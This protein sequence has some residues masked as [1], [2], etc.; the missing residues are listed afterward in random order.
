MNFDERAIANDAITDFEHTTPKTISRTIDTQHLRNTLRKRPAKFWQ[1]YL[2]IAS[3]ASPWHSEGLV[4]VASEAPDPIVDPIAAVAVL[5]SAGTDGA[6]AAGVKL[7][8]VLQQ[9]GVAA[10]W[11]A[12]A[13]VA[14]RYLPHAP[15]D[16]VT[17]TEQKVAALDSIT[18]LFLADSG[19]GVNVREAMNLLDLL[20]VEPEPFPPV[21][22]QQ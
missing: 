2:T 1:E 17:T 9:S 21:P 12:Y 11:D 14:P 7:W 15:T 3:P 16:N 20:D 4:H 18:D 22:A 13:D 6:D 19:D 5:F 10:F 8:G